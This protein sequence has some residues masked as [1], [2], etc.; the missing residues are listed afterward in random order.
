[1]SEVNRIAPDPVPL[2]VVFVTGREVFVTGREVF[3]TGRDEFVTLAG[4][5][6]LV[7]F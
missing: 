7:M 6:V 1:L 4:V 5:E 3:V 2:F